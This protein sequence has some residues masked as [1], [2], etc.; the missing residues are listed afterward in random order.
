MFRYHLLKAL[1]RGVELVHTLA[2]HGTVDELTGIPNKGGT[3]E[4]LGISQPQLRL[5]SCFPCYA[6]T[7]A[8]P[9]GVIATNRGTLKMPHFTKAALSICN[10]WKNCFLTSRQG[11][12]VLPALPWCRTSKCGKRRTVVMLGVPRPQRRS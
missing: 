8:V 10:L 3:G 5:A 7:V 2:Q 11:K 6:A 12:G 9:S 4:A 1:G